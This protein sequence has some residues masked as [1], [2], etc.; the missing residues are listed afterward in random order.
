MIKKTINNFLQEALPHLRIAVIGDVMVDRYV[1]GDVSRISPEAPVPVNRVEKMKEVLGGAANVAANLGQLHTQVFL[2]GLVG[3][4][5]HGQLLDDLI[6][7]NHIDGTG[8]I[9]SEDRSTITKMRILGARQQMMRL[10]FETIRDANEAEE[11]ALITWLA[12]LCQSGLDG[13]VV[14]DY[15]K[16]VCTDSVLKQVFALANDHKIPTI[17]DPKG[18]QWTKYDGA[19]LIT[20]NVKELSERVGHAIENTDQAVVAAAKEVLA[21]NDLEYVVATRS[22]KGISVI[23]KDGRT[24]HNPATQQDVFDVSG[25]GDTVVAMMICAVASGLSMRTAL[26]VAN[27]AAGIVVSKVG[28]YPIHRQELIDL[29]KSMQ[30]GKVVQKALYSRKEIADLVQAWQDHGDTVVFTNGCFDI[31][32]RGHV[33]YLQEAAQLGD[34]LIIGLNSDASVRRLKGD[35]RPLV[36]QEDRAYLLSALGCVD[37]VVLFEEDTPAELLA[38]IR[39]NILVKGGDYKPEEVI[40]RESVD[41]VQILSFKE[42]YSTTNIVKKIANLAKEGKL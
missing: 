19:T 36:G 17:V 40:G 33:T 30:E 32:H 10:D 38:A 20:P 34:H 18:N 11:E 31:L 3:N 14:S 7:A 16:G 35:T 41:S 42:G 5:N 22:E 13:I 28:T 23:A 8:L 26:H 2:G 4:D 25:A 37:G 21:V 39:P 29:W 6:Q 15:G 9:K 24:W 1:F 12:D 27:G